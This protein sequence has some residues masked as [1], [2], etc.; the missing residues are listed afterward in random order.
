MK[1]AQLYM[2]DPPF[3]QQFIHSNIHILCMFQALCSQLPLISLNELFIHKF[4][5]NQ[6]LD[7]H[8]TCHGFVFSV[9]VNCSRVSYPTNPSRCH[10]SPFLFITTCCSPNHPTQSMTRSQFTVGISATGWNIFPG[11]KAAADLA[12]RQ[13]ASSFVCF[14]CWIPSPWICMHT[15]H[16]S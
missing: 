16:T 5:L 14:H 15:V 10:I 1:P 8:D 6:F 11:G 9:S 2:A 3:M 12:C 7:F 4:I 13:S